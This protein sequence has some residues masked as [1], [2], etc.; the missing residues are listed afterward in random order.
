LKRSL[1][2]THSDDILRVRNEGRS[3]AHKSLVL[4]ILTNEITQNRIAV[5]AGRTVGG[6]VQRNLAK[7]RIRSAIQYFYNDLEKG[8][9][10][11]LIARQS[12]LDIEYHMLVS[13]LKT[14]LNRAGILKDKKN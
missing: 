10:I 2:L 5:I 4:G 9:D 13:A 3:Y 7:R 8:F 1:R 14:L 12:I 6:A 11:V